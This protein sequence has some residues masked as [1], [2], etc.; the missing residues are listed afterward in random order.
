MVKRNFNNKVR[1]K[2][3]DFKLHN[4]KSID[5]ILRML[6][7]FI[8]VIGLLILILSGLGGYDKWIGMPRIFNN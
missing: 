7:V 3:D 5:R 4:N 6:L 8:L 1:K 2:E